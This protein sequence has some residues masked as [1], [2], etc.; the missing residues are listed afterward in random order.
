[1]TTILFVHGT[2]VRHGYAEDLALVRERLAARRPDIMVAACH[3]ADK[4]LGLRTDLPT[5]SASIPGKRFARGEEAADDPWIALW[6]ALYRDPLYEL[7]LLVVLPDNAEIPGDPDVIAD[8]LRVLRAT[9]AGFTPSPDLDRLLITAG[10]SHRFVEA[11][12]DVAAAE[13]L[14]QLINVAAQPPELVRS[15]VARAVVAQTI[16]YRVSGLIR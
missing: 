1:M 5:G 9:L 7:R 4:T 2:G 10:L 6:G 11:C 3:W 13:P 15:A 12:G 14:E 8:E 16:A